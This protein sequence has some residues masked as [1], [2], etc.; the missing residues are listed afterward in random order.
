M[1]CTNCNSDDLHII[2]KNLFKGCYCF[3]CGR[4][5][6]INICKHDFEPYLATMSNGNTRITKICKHCFNTITTG[7]KKK[8]YN[9]LTI[10]K[11]TYVELNENKSNI[12]NLISNLYDFLQDYKEQL[13][14]NKDDHW[15]RNYKLYLQ[16]TQW[17]L[18]R[19]QVLQRDNYICQNCEVIKATEIHHLHYRNVMNENLEDLI[20]L[21]IPCHCLYHD[22]Y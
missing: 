3:S 15:W 12:Y 11:T 22:K 1:N 17:D 20:S 2:E 6:V 9:T 8:D 13:R 14:L 7:L 19:K 16:S 21:C 5:H 18:K 4:T 10:K